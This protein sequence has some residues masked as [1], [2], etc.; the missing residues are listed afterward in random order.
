MF[1]KLIRYKPNSPSG[2]TKEILFL[3]IPEDLV[4][5]LFQEFPITG[6]CYSIRFTPMKTK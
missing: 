5:I 6:K 3:N 1:Y 4:S 2:K